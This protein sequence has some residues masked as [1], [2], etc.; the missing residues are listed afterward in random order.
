MSVLQRHF[1]GRDGHGR[2]GELDE[3]D[4]PGV[5]PRQ[6][7]RLTSATDTNLRRRQ[8]PHR[9]ICIPAK[10]YIPQRYLRD[11]SNWLLSR[12][13]R[14]SY[15]VPRGPGYRPSIGGRVG[16]GVDTSEPLP[17]QVLKRLTSLPDVQEQL[18][19]EDTTDKRR[20]TR[21]LGWMQIQR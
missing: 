4:V 14:Q 3:V 1:P 12:R 21:A 13:S 5:G 8:S 10:N 15:L 7:Q 6:Q 9:S 18:L 16:P 20:L 19:G 11:M 2:E 17:M